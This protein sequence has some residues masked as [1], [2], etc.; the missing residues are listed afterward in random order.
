M[1]EILYTVI[2]NLPVYLLVFVRIA[3]MFLLSP[4][5]GR[6][7]IPSRYKISFSLALTIITVP[8]ILNSVNADEILKSAGTG[9]GLVFTINIF[10]EMIVG[11]LLGFVTLI[12]LNIAATAGQV[13]DVA[14]GLGI[15][16]VFDAQTNVQM[17]L[18]GAFLNTAMFIYFIIANGHLMLI[19]ILNYTFTSAP[20][21]QVKIGSDLLMLLSEQFFLTFSIAVSL[22][23]PVIAMTFIIEVGMGILTRAIPQLHAYLV[24]IPLKIIVGF[25]VLLFLQPL[26]INFC[27]NV[28]DKLYFAT[29]QVALGLGG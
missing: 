17:P 9:I 13:I 6:K 12:F 28:F 18:I 8:T 21:G 5:F 4:V 7:N 16:S 25:S 27:E 26:Y 15:G 23:L 24:G 1:Q 29:E 3:S 2:E 10:K 14:M 11:I 20:V 22:M 19:R